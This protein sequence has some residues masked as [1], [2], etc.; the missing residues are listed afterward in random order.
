MGAHSA[1]PPVRQSHQGSRTRCRNGARTSPQVL[2]QE[3]SN[4]GP[5][6]DG[7]RDSLE[8]RRLYRSGCR[9]PLIKSYYPGASVATIRSNVSRSFGRESSCGEPIDR[10]PVIVAHRDSWL[11][12]VAVNPA[13]SPQSSDAEPASFAGVEAICS[14]RKRL[15]DPSRQLP[16]DGSLV[17]LFVKSLSVVDLTQCALPQ[18]AQAFQG[19]CRTSRPRRELRR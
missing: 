15:D 16:P 10:F 11:G 3:W 7:D 18:K 9:L 4:S 1:F 17:A 6:S 13:W 14:G 19:H 12:S 8:C 2:G 5:S